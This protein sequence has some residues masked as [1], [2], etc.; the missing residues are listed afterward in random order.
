MTQEKY[1][2]FKYKFRM[3]YSYD[4]FEKRGDRYSY[5][6]YAQKYT[7][8]DLK[9]F[10]FSNILA[11]NHYIRSM[12]EETYLEFINK[13]QSAYYTFQKDLKFLWEAID[14]TNKKYAFLHLF[15]GIDKDN[16]LPEYLEYGKQ[17]K[18]SLMTCFCLE[19]LFNRAEVWYDE[20][21]F[22]MSDFLLKVFKGK[23]FVSFNKEKLSNIFEKVMLE[24]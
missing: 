5:I 10:L 24:V 22:V 23:D 19:H 9:L 18:I 3:N 6:K 21:N 13:Y 17:G 14:E 4:K 20:D 15:I 1:N 2:S 12:D 16:K 11:G 8:K 7:D